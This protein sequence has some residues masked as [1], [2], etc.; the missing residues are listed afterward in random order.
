[1][2]EKS[3][4][5]SP[6]L[7]T[8]IARAKHIKNAENTITPVSSPEARGVLVM[9]LMKLILNLMMTL[10]MNIMLLEMQVLL[11]VFLHDALLDIN[12]LLMLSLPHL[13]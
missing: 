3:G 2:L 13:L 9:I 1:M 6:F 10:L 4:S 8:T 12:C 7:D 11:K 5:L